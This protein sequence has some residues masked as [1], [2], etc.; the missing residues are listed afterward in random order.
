MPS[1]KSSPN[2]PHKLPKAAL[3]EIINQL[4]FQTP[5]HVGLNLIGT[6][7]AWTHNNQPYPSTIRLYL[8]HDNLTITR[9]AT[10]I[11]INL[12]DPE[13]ITKLQ[14]TLNQIAK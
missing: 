2:D 5:F 6:A 7:V 8:N 13:L 9:A 11:R 1:T 12:A 14:E 10:K 3:Q 4:D